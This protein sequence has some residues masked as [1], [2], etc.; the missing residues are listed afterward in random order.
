MP[1]ERVNVPVPLYGAVPPV[2]LTVTVELPPLHRIGVFDELTLNP[3]TVRITSSLLIWF[4]HGP[5]SVTVS[6]RV[7][8]R[9]APVTDTPVDRVFGEA[10]L[11]PVQLVTH[12]HVVEVIG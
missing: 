5:E 1:A 2:A 10:M 8:V 9:G 11:T 6:R 4:A 3:P 7:T 12:D